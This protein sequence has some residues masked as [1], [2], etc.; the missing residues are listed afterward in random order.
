MRVLLLALAAF[1]LQAEP[2]WRTAPEADVLLHPFSYEPMTIRL[3]AAQPVRLHFVN[4]SAIRLS[5]S[6]P[7]FFA[8][9]RI[10]QRDAVPDGRF[11]LAPSEE[12]VIALVPAAGRYRARS[13]NAFH[14]LRGMR[15]EIIVE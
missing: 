8:A 10:R 1:A 14:R 11:E 7:E 15:A 5:F 12:R 3:A 4:N 2:E 6:A 9:A 13:A